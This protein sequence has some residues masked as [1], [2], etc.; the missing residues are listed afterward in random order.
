[1]IGSLS[2]KRPLNFIFTILAVCVF[3]SSLVLVLLQKNHIFK[4]YHSLH[5]THTQNIASFIQKDINANEE[6]LLY[7]K[8]ELVEKYKEKNSK[9]SDGELSA[10]LTSHLRLLP[11]ILAIIT[12]TPEDREVHVPYASSTDSV[13]HKTRPWYIAGQISAG[14][15]VFTEPYTDLNTSRKIYSMSLPVSGSD[16]KHFGVVS[17]D[18]DVIKGERSLK[19]LASPLPNTKY[20]ITREGSV[21][22]SSDSKD[23]LTHIPDVMSNIGEYNG[24]FYLPDTKAYYY[25]YHISHPDWYLLIKVDRSE[26]SNIAYNKNF[27]IFIITTILLLVLAT[28]WWSMRTIL[29]NIYIRITGSIQNGII[30]KKAADELLVEKIKNTTLQ[31]DHVKSESLTDSLTGL[32]NRRAFDADI[33]KK[34]SNNNAILAL[35]DID[36]FKLI[37]DSFGHTTGDIVLKTVAS[38]GMRLC[39]LSDITLYRYGGEEIA[40]IFTDVNL[41]DAIKWLEN[42]KNEVKHRQFRE[43]NLKV[44]FSGGVCVLSDKKAEDAIAIADGY[45]YQAKSMGKDRIYDGTKI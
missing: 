5:N 20:L 23:E 26:Y 1:M 31:M 27:P 24:T 36:N 33:Q 22:L 37:N 12:S 40:V 18:I 10:F 32:K 4:H 43:P 11:D 41:D 14:D 6:S 28:C 25:Y 29:N 15:V 39:G 16:G 3:L 9:M 34:S 45:L 13:D 8:S 30:E 19:K 17:F 38:F 42:W 35:I 44:T 7:L 2:F 21:V